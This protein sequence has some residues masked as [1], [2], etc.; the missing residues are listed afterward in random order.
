MRSLERAA[1]FVRGRGSGVAAQSRSRSTR[2]CGR[3]RPT[4][5][6]I[7]RGSK[8]SES[9]GDSYAGEGGEIVA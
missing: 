7:L 6:K 4:A 1:V 2:L 8:L 9:P 5:V 3:A